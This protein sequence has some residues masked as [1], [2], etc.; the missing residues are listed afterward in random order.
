MPCVVRDPG[1][2]CSQAMP[3]RLPGPLV[4]CPRHPV[5]PQTRAPPSCLEGLLSLSIC[6]GFALRQPRAPSTWSRPSWG[7]A[8]AWAPVPADGALGREV[9]EG[10]PGP[11]LS[12]A[13]G[14]RGA[15]SVPWLGGKSTSVSTKPRPPQVWTSDPLLPAHPSG[16][17]FLSPGRGLSVPEAGRQENTCFQGCFQT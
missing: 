1:S 7:R 10:E 16:R 17:A 13:G 2:S 12:T 14:W 3:A 6:L 5:L 8:G 4:S 11:W 9:R 15:E